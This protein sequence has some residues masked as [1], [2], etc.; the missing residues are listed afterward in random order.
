MQLEEPPPKCE[1]MRWRT[2]KIRL[3]NYVLIVVGKVLGLIM[4]ILLLIV[5]VVV[6]VE[7]YGL[8]RG[9]VV[10]TEIK[11][12]SKLVEFLN[13]EVMLEEVKG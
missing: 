12:V 4:H 5:G 10:M 8:L 6:V 2:R 13:H 9:V 11:K 7:R 1:V 3:W